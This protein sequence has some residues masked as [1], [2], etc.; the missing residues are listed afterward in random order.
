MGLGVLLGRKPQ[1]G[2]KV[3]ICRE[4]GLTFP[5]D[6]RDQWGRHVVRCAERHDAEHQ[7]HIH[8]EQ[9]SIFTSPAD[10]EAF[11]WIRRR[12]AAGKKAT[13]HGRPA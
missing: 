12:A 7:Q 10:P 6:Q 4:C 5:R 13:K 2:E 11:A 8:D 1:Q 9:Q 3:Y